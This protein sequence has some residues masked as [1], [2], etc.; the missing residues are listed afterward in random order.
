MTIPYQDVQGELSQW[1]HFPQGQELENRAHGDGEAPPQGPGLTSM[2]FRDSGPLDSF[3]FEQ[4][5]VADTFADEQ[6]DLTDMQLLDLLDVSAGDWDGSDA[7]QHA[8][9]WYSAPDQVA[10][11]PASIAHV[12]TTELPP[13]IGNSTDESP[14][15]WTRAI[16]T[17]HVNTG[18]PY[19]VCSNPVLITRPHQDRRGSSFSASSSLSSSYSYDTQYCE[20][21]SDP[22]LLEPGR[23]IFVPWSHPSSHVGSGNIPLQDVSGPSVPD[24]SGFVGPNFSSTLD[25]SSNLGF[26]RNTLPQSMIASQLY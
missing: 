18:S 26:G 15:M 7:N 3:Y 13:R 21:R 22:N 11:S 16:G 12:Q 2:P 14:D 8:T 23:E 4:N 19:E 24:L 10:T 9:T 20:G 17:V 5:T 1:I 6:G 25:S